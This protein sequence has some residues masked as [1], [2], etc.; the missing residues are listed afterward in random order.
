MVYYLFSYSYVT[1]SKAILIACGL[2]WIIA[3]RQK[4]PPKN[5]PVRRLVNILA[6]ELDKRFARVHVL[7]DAS[8]LDRRFK[9]H[10][11][12]NERNADNTISRVVEATAKAA[13]PTSAT[14]REDGAAATAATSA[15]RQSVPQF[16]AD[17]EES[18][19]SLHPDNQNP[20]TEA[21]LKVKG[22]L[23][24]QF[25]PHTADPLQWWKVRGLAYRNMS[26][27]MQT[28]LWHCCHCCHALSFL[29]QDKSFRIGG[30]A[31][32]QVKCASWHFWMPIW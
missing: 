4:N 12:I 27:V 15:E 13:A 17:F 1:G 18:V 10:A 30:A 2:Q 22:F 16:W 19:T 9:K 20:L 24:E 26:I 29:K 14:E 7:A 23:F 6:C 31:S 5:E 32:A 3:H 25:I 28:R 8:F 21:M 11:F